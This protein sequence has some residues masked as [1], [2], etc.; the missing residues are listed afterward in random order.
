MASTEPTVCAPSGEVTI[1]EA[2]AFRD[3]LVTLLGNDGP[4]E[5]DLSSIQLMDGAGMQLVL[6]AKRY[7]RCSITKVEGKLQEMMELMGYASEKDI[8]ADESM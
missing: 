2:S 5:L 8:D 7:E 3:S 1:F 6:A 4:V